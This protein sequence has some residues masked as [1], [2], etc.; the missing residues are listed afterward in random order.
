MVLEGG[1]FS[2][3]S[4]GFAGPVRGGPAGKAMAWRVA[5]AP[6]GESA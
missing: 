3:A 4:D 1:C 5:G 2:V 6:A